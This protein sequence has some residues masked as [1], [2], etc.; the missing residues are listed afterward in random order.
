[1]VV[2][3]QLVIDGKPHDGGAGTYDVFNPARPSELVGRAPAADLGQLDA[4][5]AAAR[6]A[7][8]EWSAM[9][10]PQRYDALVAAANAATTYAISVDLATMYTREHGKVRSEAEFE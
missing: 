6:R 4:A 7:F 9:S 10:V 3:A 2:D 1:M 8:G 5:V